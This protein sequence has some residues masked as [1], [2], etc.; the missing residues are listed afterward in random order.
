MNEILFLKNESK[1]FEPKDSE[2]VSRRR[3]TGQIT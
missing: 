3:Q 1:R 2:N